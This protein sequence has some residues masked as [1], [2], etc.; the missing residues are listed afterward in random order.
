LVLSEVEKAALLPADLRCPV[1]EKGKVAD[2]EALGDDGDDVNVP[3]RSMV[4]VDG[5]HP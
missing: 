1:S 3:V 5:C 4:S 2:S